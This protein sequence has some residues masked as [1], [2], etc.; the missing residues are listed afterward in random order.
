A[1]RITYTTPSTLTSDSGNEYEAHVFTL[2]GPLTSS[3][4]TLTV[5]P[6]TNPPVPSASAIIRSDG[7][8][9]VGVSFDERVNPADVV[10]ANFS[11]I[12][13]TSSTIRF[14]TNTYN[15]YKGILFDTTGLTAANAYTV[16]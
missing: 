1:T 9:Q 2:P 3:I 4:V 10:P 14:P 7:E 11:L 12:G 8:V 5:L 16:P 15:D 6:D 13:G